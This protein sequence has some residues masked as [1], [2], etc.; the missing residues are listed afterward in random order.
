MKTI[1][2]R[3]ANWLRNEWALYKEAVKK[4]DDIKQYPY[5]NDEVIA[6]WSQ[7]SQREED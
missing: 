5:D 7:P 6:G 2:S 4:G 3:F 1:F